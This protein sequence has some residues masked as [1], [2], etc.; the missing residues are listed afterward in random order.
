MS[1]LVEMHLTFSNK[2]I[3]INQISKVAM[4]RIM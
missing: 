2:V 4:Q 1:F 3:D